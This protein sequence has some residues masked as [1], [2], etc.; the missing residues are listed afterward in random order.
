MLR[1][2]TLT[3][4]LL[5]ALPLGAE[6]RLAMRPSA[7][8]A[9]QAGFVESNLVFMF[10]HEVA[11]ALIDVLGLQV[12]GR[13]EDAADTLSAILIDRLR[14]EQA[15][16]SLFYDA[17]LA[18]LY[19]AEETE[20]DSGQTRWGRHSLDIERYD[21]LVCLFY[22]ANPDDRAGLA[23]TLGLTDARRR[24]CPTIFALAAEDWRGKLAG[25][26]P[27][28]HGPG[29]RLV[30][31]AGRDALTR[32]IAAEVRALNGEYGWPRWVDVT[33]EPC[34]EAN[35]FYDPRARRIVVCTEYAEDL[36]RL[37]RSHHGD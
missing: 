18:F 7:A 14:D 37:W 15:A 2:L 19:Y 22:G 26:P 29:L 21:N 24:A 28:D 4:S 35:A 11:H 5:F 32:V 23:R 13:E 31:P 1:P 16:V 33:V 20:A 10:H 6:S 30:V 36:G 8:D 27:Q 25:M 3:V 9:A 17:A 12:E 34:G